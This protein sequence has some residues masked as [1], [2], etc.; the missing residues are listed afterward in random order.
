MITLQTRVH[1]EG[2]TGQAIYR[3][4]LTATDREY[5]A[6]W[7]GVHLEFHP[8][9]RSLGD[10]G[11]VVYMDEFVGP[12]RVRGTGVVVEAV[13]GKKIVWQMAWWVRLPVWLCLE[14][15]DDPRGVSITHTVRAGFAGFGR[16]LDP[17]LRCYLSRA[18]A[19]A[20]DEHVKAEFPRLR[21]L[22]AGAAG[23]AQA[24]GT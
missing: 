18:F 16:V 13:P 7:P 4:M 22:L 8:V 17:L 6:W 19:A 10:V 24:A 21:D 9:R 1:L 14:L 23:A 3:F 11:T 12:F 2:V 20:L 5:R 15:E